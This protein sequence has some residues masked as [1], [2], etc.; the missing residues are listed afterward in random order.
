M[1]F[2]GGIGVVS[3]RNNLALFASLAKTGKNWCLKG[4]FGFDQTSKKIIF[5][6]FL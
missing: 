4:T 6:L 2:L 3:E 1:I 5:P